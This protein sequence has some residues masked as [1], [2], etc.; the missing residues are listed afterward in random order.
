[1]NTRRPI[2]EVPRLA[3]LAVRTMPGSASPAEQL[4]AAG[5]DAQSI[6]AAARLLVETAVVR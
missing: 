1:M 3:R 2:D 4:R 6:A 5:I